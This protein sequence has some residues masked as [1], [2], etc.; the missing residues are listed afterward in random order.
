VSKYLEKRDYKGNL[1]AKLKIILHMDLKR[2]CEMTSWFGP[3]CVCSNEPWVTAMGGELLEQLNNCGL[4][5]NKTHGIR[6]F[7]KEAVCF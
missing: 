7:V 3:H 2:E 6:N 5:K 4:L 1:R